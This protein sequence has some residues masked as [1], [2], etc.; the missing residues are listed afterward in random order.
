MWDRFKTA[1]KSIDELIVLEIIVCLL[2]LNIDSSTNRAGNENSL[3]TNILLA[4]SIW[5]AF[6][7]TKVVYDHTIGRKRLYAQRTIVDAYYKNQLKNNDHFAHLWNG[8]ILTY[9][10]TW[11]HQFEWNREGHVSLQKQYSFYLFLQAISGVYSWIGWSYG[12][13]LFNIVLLIVGGLPSATIMMTSFRPFLYIFETSVFQCKQMFAYVVSKTV[14]K[15]LNILVSTLAETLTEFDDVYGSGGFAGAVGFSSGNRMPVEFVPITHTDVLVMYQKQSD[16]SGIFAFL[17]CVIVQSLIFYFKKAGSGSYYYIVDFAHKYQLW[18]IDS[19][20]KSTEQIIKNN[21]KTLT[22]HIVQRRWEQF[23]DPRIVNMIFEIYESKYNTHYLNQMSNLSKSIQIAWFRIS[24]ITA[25]SLIHP[26]MALAIDFYFSFVINVYGVYQSYLC[27]FIGACVLWGSSSVASSIDDISKGG[28]G[29]GATSSGT[30]NPLFG[31]S[32]IVMGE[33]LTRPVL[34]YIQDYE[35]YSTYF[36]RESNQWLMLMIVPLVWYLKPL[37]IPVSLGL[38]YINRQ[39]LYTFV[40]GNVV[41][42][43][44]LSNFT[45]VHLIFLTSLHLLIINIC[46]VHMAMAELSRQPPPALIDDYI[47]SRSASTLPPTIMVSSS[48]T[49]SAT[50]EAEAEKKIVDQHSASRETLAN[51]SV[52]ARYNV[53]KNIS[54]WVWPATAPAKN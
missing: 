18:T 46:S 30:G 10:P 38:Y 26:L 53:C 20:T 12:I 32:L 37:A 34:E 13:R 9:F 1:V 17:K 31:A 21:L 39:W 44:W 5:S 27:Y 45:L 48:M 36:M 3:M 6:Q 52:A 43:G 40:I 4:N 47:T 28:T 23:L 25:F 49:A 35:L 16:L 19:Y 42:L 41:F 8:W 7:F 33:V 2:V 54:T 24:M 51:S 14:A 22:Q 50:I 15:I 11:Q 29:G